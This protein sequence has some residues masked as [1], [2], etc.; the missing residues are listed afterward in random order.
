VSLRGIHLPTTSESDLRARLAE[1]ENLRSRTREVHKRNVLEDR[2][3]RV[4]AELWRRTQ[5]PTDQGGERRVARALYNERRDTCSTFGSGASMPPWEELD[6]DDQAEWIE[7]ARVALSTD[8]A[9]PTDRGGERT[10][11]GAKW[12][13]P[14][15]GISQSDDA[16]CWCPDHPDYLKPAGERTERQEGEG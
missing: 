7:E 8:P 16:M 13:C 14:R 6:A 5:R 2:I 1:L 15:H 9:R 10:A 4:Q 12:D 3:T 11:E